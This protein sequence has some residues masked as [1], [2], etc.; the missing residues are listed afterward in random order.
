MFAA[1]HR[2]VQGVLVEFYRQA[3]AEQTTCLAQLCAALEASTID[4]P[5]RPELTRFASIASVEIQRHREL[6][7]ILEADMLGIREFFTRLIEAGKARQ[8]IAPDVTTEAAV[9]MIIASLFG[10]AWLRA[11]V[12]SAAEHGDAIRAFQRLLRGGL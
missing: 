10:L 4:E 6:G 1:V 11:Q 8:E 9:N 7:Q 3:F 2:H 12:G 5:V